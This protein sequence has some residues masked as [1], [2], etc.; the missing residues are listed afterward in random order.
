[1]QGPLN[2]DAARLREIRLPRPPLQ[3]A[4]EI[5]APARKTRL[6]EEPRLPQ[7]CQRAERVMR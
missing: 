5:H 3:C 1:M 4:A 6:A 2:Y 7:R